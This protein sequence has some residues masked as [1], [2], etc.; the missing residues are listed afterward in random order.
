MLKDK[1][2]KPTIPEKLG[3]LYADLIMRTAHFTYNAPRA[4]KFVNTV[5]KILQERL[6][7]LKEVP[8]TPEYKKARYGNKKRRPKG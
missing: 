4:R 1:S 2:N 7:E 3:G 6:P 5:I 8:A